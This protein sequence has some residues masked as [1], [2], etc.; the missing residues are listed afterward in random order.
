MTQRSGGPWLDVTHQ[1]EVV[2]T[3]VSEVAESSRGLR[4]AVQEPQQS[5]QTNTV[6][7]IFSFQCFSIPFKS[8][9]HSKRPWHCNHRHSQK[10]SRVKFPP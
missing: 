7:S 4:L 8:P 1:Q 3:L 9:A 10:G 2:A 5:I 6:E